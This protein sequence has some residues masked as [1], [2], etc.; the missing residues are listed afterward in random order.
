[1][2]ITTKLLKVI[3]AFGRNVIYWEERVCNGQR[4]SPKAQAQPDVFRCATTG[5]ACPNVSKRYKI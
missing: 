3:S 4:N 2:S 5:S 1:M